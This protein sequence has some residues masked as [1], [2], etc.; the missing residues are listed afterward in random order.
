MSLIGRYL[1]SNFPSFY[2]II[3]TVINRIILL[4]RPYSIHITDSLGGSFKKYA[5]EHDM[6]STIH[7]LKNDLDVESLEL[8]EVI[9]KRVLHYPD[10]SNKLPTRKHDPII[11]GLL[12]VETK[13]FRQ[14]IQRQLMLEAKT[15]N[16]PNHLLEES[17]FY[18]YHGLSLL[19]TSVNQYIE[20][21]HFLDIG[22]YV[23]DSA[24]AL[25]KY[26]YSKVF[27]LEISRKSIENYQINLG[28]AQIPNEKYSIINLGVASTDDQPAI[29]MFDTGSAGLS[30]YRRV[31]KYDEIVV[32]RK[33]IDWIVKE[34]SI[35]PRFIKV[36]IEG[37]SMDFVKGASKTLTEFR[38]VLSIAIYHNPIEFFEVKPALEQ[39]LD[40]Y[41]F[42]IRKL[43][44]S[45]KNNQVHSEVVL[46]AYPNEL[47]T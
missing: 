24:I 44:S 40:N 3:T 12:P 6:P 10:E 22:A 2:A 25:Y 45:V 7:L 11:G 5:T 30:P 42:L 37:A 38:P 8:I 39:L 31:G 17:V 28:K 21:Q 14:S 47:H 43:S 1:K 15:N 4:S 27:S 32:E 20:G 13:S 19:P 23:G 16:L 41:T 36:D 46:L 18:F 29:K 33:S 26:R 35:Q 34:Y 9:V